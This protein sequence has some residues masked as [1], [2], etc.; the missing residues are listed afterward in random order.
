[1]KVVLGAELVTL[2]LL[3]LTARVDAYRERRHAR[4]TPGAHQKRRRWLSRSVVVL[5][6]LVFV[7]MAHSAGADEDMSGRRELQ[8][9]HCPSAVTVPPPACQ[10]RR[11][12]HRHGASAPRSARPTRDPT[13]RTV[14]A[15]GRR[16]ARAQRH[17]A[18]RPRHRQRPLRLLP[19]NDGAH[20]H[21]RGVD[22]R[23]RQDAHPSRPA[24]GRAPAAV[25]HPAA[26]RMLGEKQQRTAAR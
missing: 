14:P 21:L 4:A 23:R 20:L 9:S 19:G 1:M 3:W 24:G 17:R 12:R 15:R 5:G 18:Y 16:S 8:M 13:A 2:A 22:Q 25:D 11:R 26:A 6:A 7:P 10:H